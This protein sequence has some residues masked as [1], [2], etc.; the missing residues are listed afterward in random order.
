MKN[1]KKYFTLFL[2]T[3]LIF[4]CYKEE[5]I[6]QNTKSS[7]KEIIVDSS[8]YPGLS[9]QQGVLNFKVSNIILPSFRMN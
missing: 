2:V 9:I 5:L 3:P 7:T 1:L 8:R 6:L 4:S